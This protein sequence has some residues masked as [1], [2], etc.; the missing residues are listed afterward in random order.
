MISASIKVRSSSSGAHRWVFAVIS[1][2]GASCRMAAS[3]SRRSPAARS[4][5]SAGAAAVMTAPR[6]RSQPAAG[7]ARREGPRPAC[8]RPGRGSAIPAPGGQDGPHVRGPPPAKR[9][10]PVQGIKERPL[11]VGRAQR[12]Q[13]GQL[14][15]QPGVPGRGG[16][17]DERPGDRPQAAELLLCRGLRPDRPPRGRPRAAVM[18][19]ADRGLTRRDEGV[20]GD[21]L[22]GGGHDDQQ[23]PVI[24][25]QPHLGADQ[26]ARARNTAPTRTGRRTAGRPCG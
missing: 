5:A 2:S 14:R 1:S 3:L 20:L 19:I 11:A 12:V 22:P 16:A 23:P 25:A 13:L 6:S 18:L 21:H 9:H 26:P 17:G 7:P 8:P 10:R 15:P 24:G 4:G